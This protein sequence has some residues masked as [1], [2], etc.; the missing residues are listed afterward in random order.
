MFHLVH[1]VLCSRLFHSATFKVCFTRPLLSSILKATTVWPLN[2]QYDSINAVMSLLLL[3]CWW[4]DKEKKAIAPQRWTLQ[5]RAAGKTGNNRNYRK[6]IEKRR[7]KNMQNHHKTRRARLNRS[8][9]TK[10][11]AAPVRLSYY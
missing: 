9:R 10:R 1:L 2:K 6:R 4:F 5:H 3:F 7:M 8:S 11:K